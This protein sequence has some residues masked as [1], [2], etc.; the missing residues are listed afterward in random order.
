[1]PSIIIKEKPFPL[2]TIK[3]L[4]TEEERALIFSE[5]KFLNSGGGKKLKVDTG[6]AVTVDGHTRKNNKGSFLERVYQNPKFSDIL[7]SGSKV[8]S[9]LPHLNTGSSW[10]LDN[11]TNA[12][13]D[14][15]AISG[16]LVSYYENGGFYKS[17]PD[18]SLLTALDWF[19]ETP[20]YFDGGDIWFPDYDVEIPIELNTTVLFPGMINHEVRPVFIEEEHRDKGLGRYVV[21]RFINVPG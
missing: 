21:A 10:Y 18:Y 6:G 14:S 17:H 13:V 4:Y 1:M 9:I 2:V 20:K 8:L 3:G 16:T 15:E 5:L 11:I 19:Y 7:S 12:L